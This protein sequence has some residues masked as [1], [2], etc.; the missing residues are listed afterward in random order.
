[1]IH[2]KL[3]SYMNTVKRMYTTNLINL[4][5]LKLANNK[6]LFIVNSV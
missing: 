4:C 3:V 5:A 6:N 2:F 1:M